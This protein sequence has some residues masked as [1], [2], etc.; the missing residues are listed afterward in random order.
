MNAIL[1]DVT[2]C[3][4]CEKCVD[5]CVA[6]HNHGPSL[7]WRWSSNDGLSG[8]RFTS[9]VRSE[10]N[11]YVRKQ[12][13]HCLDPAC[14]TACPVGALTKT[15][16]GAV[17]YDA[18][19]CM[20][21]RYCMMS[22]PFGIPRYTWN[23]NVP[24]V[25]KCSMCYE[26]RLKDGKQPACTEACPEGATIFG[27]RDEL[28]AEA[29]RKMK[30]VFVGAIITIALA[31]CLLF[32]FDH[33]IVVISIILFL[34]F[35]AFTLLEASLPSLI[36]KT[37]PAGKK[38]TAMGIYSSSQFLGI[39][40]GGTLGGL[41][42]RHCGLESVFLFCG[43]IGLL[44]AA[45]AITMKKPLHL[46]SKIVHLASTL[47]ANAASQLQEKLL[48]LKGVND[49]MICPDES[50]AY[51]KVDKKVLDEDELKNVVFSF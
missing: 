24:L 43:I 4:G 23:E 42:F 25:S 30:Q 39:F 17:V 40:V 8:S 12:C 50:L 45:V 32:F 46:S 47:N 9:V 38:G 36:A 31:Q 20:G 5:A 18:H 3:V 33:N 49:A 51:L 26:K 37:A 48:A 41:I 34:F 44:W 15:E 2:K 10:G 35:T 29:K 11:A 13:R 6:E 14:V 7:R 28:I 16:S 19:K 22:C 1:T 21:C 27:D